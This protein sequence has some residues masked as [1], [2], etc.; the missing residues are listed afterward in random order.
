MPRYAATDA[1]PTQTITTT[2]PVSD[3]QPLRPRARARAKSVGG[4]HGRTTLP[5]ARGSPQSRPGPPET[6]ATLAAMRRWGARRLVAAGVA[7]VVLAAGLALVPRPAGAATCTSAFSSAFAQDLAQRYPGIKVTAAVYDTRTGCWHHLHKGLQLTTASVIKAQVLGA[8]LLQAQDAGRGLTAWERSQIG[9][10]IRYSFNPETSNLY[11]YVGYETRH[12]RQRRALRRHRR[13]PTRATFG[14]TRSTAVDRTNVALRLLYGG[15]GLRQ[16]GRE[17][18]W[19][20]MTDVHPL[21]EW[22]ISAGVPAGWTVA[23]KNGFY[24]STGHRLASRVERVRAP[25]RRRPGLRHHGDDRGR[26]RTSA[27]GIRLV[28][29]VARRAAAALTVGPGEARPIDRARCVL[30][31]GGESWTGVAARL[32]PPEQPRRRACAPPPAA[33]RHRCRASRPAR[34]TSPR[35]P[36]SSRSSVNGRYRA[37]GHRPRLRRP[38]RPPLVRPRRRGATR[39]GPGTPTGASAPRSM[40]VGGDYIP[41][42]GDFDGDG[43]G[44]VLWYGPGTR[45]DS[46]WYGGGA[47]RSASRRR[48]HGL[49][50][51]PRRGDFDGDGRDDVLWYR[52]GSGGD[53][54]WYGRAVDGAFDS[55]GG[56]GHRRLRARRRRPR[57]RRRRRRLL[58]RA[59]ARRPRASGAA[60]SASA[61]FV[62]RRP[63]ASN[64]ALPAGRR[65]RRRGRRRRDHLVR[66]RAAARLPLVRTAVVAH[67]SRAVDDQR[68]LPA[69]GRR[70]RRRRPRRHRLVRPGRPPRRRCG[71]AGRTAASPRRHARA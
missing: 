5:A 6:P 49:G 43:C 11:G 52:P 31:S 15:G 3:Q 10:M 17:E 13:R 69:R 48:R 20:Y 50:Y 51:V 4:R 64:G 22:G 12:A 61:S 38:R 33:T 55:I 37:G 25:G 56:H 40:S 7:A 27:P 41:V 8:V 14:L 28:E 60:R 23:Q 24:P 47:V 67:R 34:R 58:V 44:D 32:G 39:G 21:Q 42:A 26:H 68:R 66:A 57:R 16:A 70:L 54:V 59:A 46:V 35:E 36:V 19:A 45:P 65:R 62:A 71:G 63:G 30:T 18:A 2:H 53:S 29:E 1:V 9:P